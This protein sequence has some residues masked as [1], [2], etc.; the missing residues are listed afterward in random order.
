MKFGNLA[1]SPV[2]DAAVG[3]AASAGLPHAAD[4]SEAG[5]GFVGAFPFAVAPVEVSRKP[6]FGPTPSV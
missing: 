2:A 6:D 1:L 3:Y 5:L 4:P